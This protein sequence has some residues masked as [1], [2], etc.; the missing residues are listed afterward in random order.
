VDL[1]EPSDGHRVCSVGLLRNS[2]SAAA[3]IVRLVLDA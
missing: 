2:Y 3:I 1:V